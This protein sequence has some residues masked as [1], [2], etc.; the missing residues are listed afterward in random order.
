MMS[1][2]RRQLDEIRKARPM[3]YWLLRIILMVLAGI[4]IFSFGYWLALFVA[5]I[6][7]ADFLHITGVLGDSFGFWN[8]VFSG[9]ALILVIISVNLQAR[10]LSQ[11]SQTF[12][13][14]SFER[15]FFNMISLF[16]DQSDELNDHKPNTSPKYISDLLDRLRTTQLDVTKRHEP[17]PKSPEVESFLGTITTQADNNTTIL[18]RF[19]VGLGYEAAAHCMYSFLESRHATNKTERFVQITINVLNF[20]CSEVEKIH[21]ESDDEKSQKL[22][23]LKYADIFWSQLLDSEIE[24][25]MI[26]AFSCYSGGKGYGWKLTQ[27]FQIAPPNIE[28]F[29][30]VKEKHLFLVEHFEQQ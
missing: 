5:A 1:V 17:K 21:A 10:E 12:Q 29:Q 9:A 18:N 16:N 27:Y 30:Q 15:T 25:L 8:S 11:V 2:F 7:D 3:T 24:F 26:Y 19:S 23:R 28:R 14:D 22:D 6:G 13:R 20:I 4:F